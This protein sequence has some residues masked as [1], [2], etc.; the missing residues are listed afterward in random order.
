[1]RYAVAGLLVVSLALLAPLAL[2]HQGP[3]GMGMMGGG[4]MRGMGGERGFGHEGPLLSLMLDLKEPLGLSL[5]QV[6]TL[7]DLRTAFEK[8]AIQRGA[9]IRL[10]ELELRE[11]LAQE[12]VDLGRTEA[13]VKKIAGLRADLRIAR[14]R[15]IEKG[16]GVLTPEQLA[17]FREAGHEMA[18]GGMGGGQMGPGMMGP[19]GP[20]GMGGRP[21]QY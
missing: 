15:A 18:R 19:G 12:T 8:E 21:G 10:A 2:A 13:L 9:E 4:M 1:M 11:A 5:Q 6:K 17:K 20:G 3:G 7:R 14:L 16:K